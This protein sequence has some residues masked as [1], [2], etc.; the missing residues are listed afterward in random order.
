[1]QPLPKMQLGGRKRR[2]KPPISFSLCPLVEPKGN[3]DTREAWVMCPVM[4]VSRGPWK[5][6]GVGWKMG[7]TGREQPTPSACPVPGDPQSQLENHRK[8]DLQ[9]VGGKED[10]NGGCLNCLC[11]IALSDFFFFFLAP[12]VISQQ[13]CEIHI[14]EVK[15]IRVSCS[16]HIY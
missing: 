16:N 3:P 6:G 14:T 7:L 11:F 8:S 5:R 2:A 13:F 4:S 15:E 1:M 12:L 9:E 10:R